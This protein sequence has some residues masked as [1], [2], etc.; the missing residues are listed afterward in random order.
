M[1]SACI[2]IRATFFQADNCQKIGL[3]NM[4]PDCIENM[5]KYRSHQSIEH[6]K[7]ILD[8]FLTFDHSAVLSPCVLVCPRPLH[9]PRGGIAGHSEQSAARLCRGTYDGWDS[10]GFR[11]LSE[12]PWAP[13]LFCDREIAR[14]SR[15]TGAHSPFAFW[16]CEYVRGCTSFYTILLLFLR[17][18]EIPSQTG[19]RPYFLGWPKMATWPKMGTPP[20]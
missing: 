4:L 1:V 16:R 9:L 7:R 15:Q 5:S 10:C 11:T 2:S 17:V 19:E 12:P 14:E 8:V 3:L 6:G 20:S 18:F 13:Q